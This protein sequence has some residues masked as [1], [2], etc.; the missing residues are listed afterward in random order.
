MLSLKDALVEGENGFRRLA[1]SKLADSGPCDQPGFGGDASGGMLPVNTSSTGR[2]I[3][4]CHLGTVL[5]GKSRINCDLSQ[6]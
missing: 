5:K 2:E 3:L 6:F 1:L 4:S